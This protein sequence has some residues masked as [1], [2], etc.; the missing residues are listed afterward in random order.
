MAERGRLGGQRT[1]LRRGD[2]NARRARA[3]FLARFTDDTWLSANGY[4]RPE[5]VSPDVHATR[6]QRD[7]FRDLGR[8]RRSGRGR[9]G[10]V[11]L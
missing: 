8:K 4:P 9:R 5:G 2:Q 11:A 6:V 7:Y 1:A 10:R 3:A